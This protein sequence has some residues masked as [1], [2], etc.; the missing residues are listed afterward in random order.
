MKFRS[1]S[2]VVLL[3]CLTSGVSSATATNSLQP[4][5][6]H[7]FSAQIITQFIER[8]H[9]K[10]TRLDNA[11]SEEILEQYLESLDPNRSF[12]TQED[13]ASF[14]RYATTLDDA[15]ARVTLNRHL[16][17]SES[18]SNAEWSAQSLLWTI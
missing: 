14:G 3:A 1:I 4:L 18:T 2:L 13:I 8:F 5:P 9:Y 17:S 10:K 12:F 7:R 6:E 11:Q 16:S 15:L